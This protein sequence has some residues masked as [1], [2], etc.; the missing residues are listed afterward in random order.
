M[1][2]PFFCMIYGEEEFNNKLKKMIKSTKV[3]VDGTVIGDDMERHSCY[4]ECCEHSL[5]MSWHLYGETPTELLNRSRPREDPEVK[6]Y[7]IEN[8]EPTTKASA[9]KA[10]DIISKIFNPNLYSIR[11]KEESES[12]KE[13]KNY[14]LENYP[15]FNSVVNYSKD[16][17]LRKMIADPNGVVAIKLKEVPIKQSV[18][19]EPIIVIY[20][21]SN[22]WNYD[23]DHYLI[24]IRTEKAKA[25]NGGSIY[26][27]Y[28]EYF[29][30]IQYI[31]FR[32]M[33]SSTNALTLEIIETYEHN[34]NQI[35]VW[36]LK[37]KPETKDNGELIYKSFFDAALPYWNLSII[38]ESDVLAAFIGHMHPLMYEVVEPC[39]YVHET[40]YRCRQGIILKDNGDKLSCPSCNG[41][42]N[43]SLGPY[44]VKKISKEKL[45]EGENGIGIMPIGY[46]D[47]PTDATKMLEARAD[48]MRNLGLWAI[49]MDVEDKVGENQSGVAKTI[50][51]SAQHDTLY[52][53]ATVVFDHLENIF[54]FFN[55]YKF[56]VLDKSQGK[57]PDKNLPQINKPTQFDITSTTE[58]INNY[59]AAKDSGLD[60]NFM[61]IKQQEIATRDLS[62]NPD[63]KAFANLLLDLDPLPGMDAQTVSLNL[64]R[65]IIR[66]IDAVVHANI[67]RFLMEAIDEDKSFLQKPRKEKVE[68]LEQKAEEM[69]KENKPK[70]NE[71]LMDPNYAGPQPRTIKKEKAEAAAA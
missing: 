21:S 31:E 34:F 38:H 20:G 6:K 51:R 7:R 11:W 35:P 23:D 41:T 54:Y 4:Q 56:G 66:Q 65:F 25:Q 30:G 48:R 10:L 57:D 68:I 63:L 27:H 17:L 28:F 26:W 14:A 59:K 50:D 71:A 40:K 53:I 52:N 46:I 19:L 16:V 47:V 9:D 33:L 69:I 24:Y 44:G 18:E 58:L 22:V 15:E 43:R 45:Q 42:G 37:G 70:L 61:Q 8:Y 12:A 62:T 36:K 29:D 64:S 55:K 49:N 2:L 32:A 1:P 67:K 5:E 60:P 13:L 3:K 39:N